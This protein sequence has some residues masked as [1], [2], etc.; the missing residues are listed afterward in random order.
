MEKE[1][2]RELAKERSNNRIQLVAEK[3]ARVGAKVEA[4]RVKQ[5]RESASWEAPC[6]TEGEDSTSNHTAAAAAPAEQPSTALVNHLAKM[7]PELTKA[8]V[9]K[10]KR[11]RA[12]L[13]SAVKKCGNWKEH[14][15]N[16]SSKARSGLERQQ[17]IDDLQG[18]SQVVAAQQLG[19]RMGCEWMGCRS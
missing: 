9:K 16:S 17:L 8:K 10:T 5:H 15:T 11:A 13:L 12:A 14:S 19:F 7:S 4:V 3:A 2:R 6:S 1:K 18:L